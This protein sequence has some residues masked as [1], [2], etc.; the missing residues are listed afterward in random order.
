MFREIKLEDVNIESFITSD[1]A[2]NIYGASTELIGLELGLLW[3]RSGEECE[4]ALETS[5][6][7]GDIGDVVGDLFGG[8]LHPGIRVSPMPIPVHPPRHYG[9]ESGGGGGGRTGGN[10]HTGACGLYLRV[11]N[12]EY[13]I[14]VNTGGPG[15]WYW[16]P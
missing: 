11:F 15:C 5:P 14:E 9:G 4:Y 10:I 13:L 1:E 8:L 7:W 2:E 12:P 3:I 6:D 16:D